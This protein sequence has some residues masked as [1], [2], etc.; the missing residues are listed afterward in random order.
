MKKLYYENPYEREFT[1]EIVNIIE[2][3]NEYHIELDKSY[4]YPGDEVQPVDFGSINEIPVLNVYE[5][6]GTVYHVL[7]TKPL[8][9][10]RVKCKIDFVKRFDFMQ[11]HSGMLILSACLK[12]LFNLAA[13]KI[14]IGE[15]AS[16]IDLNKIIEKEDIVKIEEI[17][18]KIVFDNVKIEMLQL[19]NAELKKLSIRKSPAKANEETTV[20]K[21]GDFYTA[22][23]NS[24][25]PASTIEV[26]MIKIIHF[27]KLAT[28]TRIEF[29]CGSRAL[30]DYLSKFEAIDKMAKLLSCEDNKVLSIVENLKGDL[31]KALTE[32]GALKAEVAD[33]E[34]QK[35]L[36]SCE[37]I[38]NVR[39]LRKTFDNA[40]LKYITTLANKLTSF[41]KVIILFGTKSEDKANLVFMCSKDI[42][43]INMGNLLKDAV[44]LIDGKGG[45]SNFSAQ[46]GG[47]SKNN[48]DSSINYAYQQVVNFILK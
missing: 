47:K 44:T 21:I 28:G 6:N 14:N 34:V 4:F 11:Q 3:N 41:P 37:N 12:E 30:A 17:A 42:K 9:I 33:Y 32:K 16:Y 5:T 20:L 24:L 1:A 48:L 8:K 15:T 40:D 29:I 13:V 36:D 23:S 27:S 43:D 25:F 7:K 38:G 18:N 31:N 45:G 10:H 2:I 46:G 35:M 19:T 22:Q 26:Q 39:I